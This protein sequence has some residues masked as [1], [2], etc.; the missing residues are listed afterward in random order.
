[1]QCPLLGHSRR[2]SNVSVTSGLPPALGPKSKGTSLGPAP[3]MP[4][5]VYFILGRVLIKPH[6]PAGVSNIRFIFKS[7]HRG[8]CWAA[9][10]MNR[11]G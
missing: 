7:R 11:N 5:W 6:V 2:F 3:L 10:A 1:M 8:G 9:N 4:P